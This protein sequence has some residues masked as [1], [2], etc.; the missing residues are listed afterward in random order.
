MF[1]YEKRSPTGISQ[2]HWCLYFLLDLKNSDREYTAD[3]NICIQAI[4]DN[5]LQQ[6][7]QLGG[8][9]N[10]S[11]Q[12]EFLRSGNKIDGKSDE[13]IKYQIKK[14]PDDILEK[15]TN[16]DHN[17]IVNTDN[18]SKP[19]Q[20]EQKS[21]GEPNVEEVF[22]YTEYFYY[23]FADL[24]LIFSDCRNVNPEERRAY[25]YFKCRKESFL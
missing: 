11:V 6:Y 14:I 20:E 21:F 8:V 15:M 25:R 4:Q 7:A 19:E 10:N 5:L 16:I 17:E 12:E 23:F 13:H 22:L 9:L 18:E 24:A 2:L 1:T 3:V